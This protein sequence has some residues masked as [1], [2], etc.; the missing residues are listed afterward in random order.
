M[1]GD[2]IVLVAMIFY[3]GQ[4]TYE[5]KFVK[6]Y[7][8]K[9]LNAIGLEGSF[10]FIILTSMLIAFY[11][12]KAPFDMGQPNGVIE[13]AI[14]AFIQMGDNPALLGSLI[15][16]KKY[17]QPWKFAYIQLLSTVNPQ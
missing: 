5:E 17:M 15:G 8:I 9:P 7:K 13:D 16:K 2:I 12:I 11:F 3:A 6:K 4:L 10:A 14:D 1:L